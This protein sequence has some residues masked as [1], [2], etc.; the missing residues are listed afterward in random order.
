MPNGQLIYQ[1]G[2]IWWTDLNPAVGYEAQKVRPCLVIQNDEGNRYSSL[3]S[4]VP[5]LRKKD[6]P[7]VVNV[8]PSKLNQLD[9]ERGL[10]FNQIKS[11]DS[12]RLKQKQGELEPYYWKT[13]ES[14][15]SKQFGFNPK[16]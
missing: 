16:F 7:F 4:V 11:L 6:Y 2:E 10:H 13:I 9:R 5:F 8:L 12:S 14:I 3:V 15:I 1:R